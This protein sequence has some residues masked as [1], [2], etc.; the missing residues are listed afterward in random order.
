MI[1]G[2]RARKRPLIR[3]AA[4]KAVI[5]RNLSVID[6]A[7]LRHLDPRRARQEGLTTILDK[8]SL[9]QAYTR[10]LSTSGDSSLQLDSVKYLHQLYALHAAGVLTDDEFSAARGRLFDS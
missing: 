5:V 2:R 8:S 10:S 7:A 9:E 4:M 6:S 3:A 1:A